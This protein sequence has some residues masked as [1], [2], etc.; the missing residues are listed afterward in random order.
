MAFKLM[1]YHVKYFW[2]ILA[3]VAWCFTGLMV[4]VAFDWWAVAMIAIAVFCTYKAIKIKAF[5]IIKKDGG[6]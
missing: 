1:S 5:K 3:T 4:W 2:I 6:I